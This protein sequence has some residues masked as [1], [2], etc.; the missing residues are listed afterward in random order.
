MT[1]QKKIRKLLIVHTRT[2]GKRIYHAEQYEKA[3]I[4]AQ[5]T[6]SKLQVVSV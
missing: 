5:A 3:L 1:K 6:Q 2:K 4:F